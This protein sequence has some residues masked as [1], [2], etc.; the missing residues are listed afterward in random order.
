MGDDAAR[1]VIAN[2]V[3]ALCRKQVTVGGQLQWEGA[4]E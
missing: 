1:V 4:T 2:V 3:I